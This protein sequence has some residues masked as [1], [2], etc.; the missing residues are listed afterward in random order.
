M[1]RFLFI[2]WVIYRIVGINLGIIIS[3]PYWLITGKN[4]LINIDSYFDR[5]CPKI[6]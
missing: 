4:V 1:Y 2:M 3:I 6:Y 5:I